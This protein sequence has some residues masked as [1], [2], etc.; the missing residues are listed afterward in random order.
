MK[1]KI[2]S[3]LASILTITTFVHA[4][5][6]DPV[7]TDS[8]RNTSEEA[9]PLYRS[10]YVELLGAS[11]LI[12]V[13][14]DCRIRPGSPFGYRAG[15]SYLSASSSYSN[16]TGFYHCEE[17]LRGFAVPVEF[18]CILG[19]RK[20]KFEVSFGMNLGVYTSRTYTLFP[21]NQYQSYTESS[22]FGYYFYTNIG[23][24]YQRKNGFML[25]VGV[26]PSFSF[27]RHGITKEPLLYPYLSLGY[28]I[29]NK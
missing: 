6:N 8:I 19:K 9:P 26:S 18:N 4:E 15:I 17:S 10:I 22:D 13:S 3:L 11:N 25:R 27:G 24:R 1:R 5:G 7:P 23:Y 2:L 20:S 28:T 14:Y 12:G 21:A 29:G 16:V